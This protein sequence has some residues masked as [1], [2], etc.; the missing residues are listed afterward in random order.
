MSSLTRKQIIADATLSAL[1]GVEQ[2]T[3][4]G[5]SELTKGMHEYIKRNKLR[6]VEEDLGL[7]PKSPD[8]S[9]KYCSTCGSPILG[10]TGSGRYCSACGNLI[11]GF[12]AYCDRCG[13]EQ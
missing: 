5:Y 2:G 10:L 13:K 8:S 1:L 7:T 12:S 9:A 11:P 6:K 4:V 3:L